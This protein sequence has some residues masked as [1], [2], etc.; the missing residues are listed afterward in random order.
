MTKR[1]WTE[2]TVRDTVS[3]PYTKR[4]SVNKATGNSAT[5][6]YNKSGGYV[7]IDDVTNAIVQVSDNINPSTWAQIQVLLTRIY[8]MH[9]NKEN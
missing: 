4:V 6:Y 3:N 1:G 2:S 5:M 7:I 8:L 9:L